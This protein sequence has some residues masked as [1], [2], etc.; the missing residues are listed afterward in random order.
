MVL[1]EFDTHSFLIVLH[2]S[3]TKKTMY[4]PAIISVSAPPLQ[5]HSLLPSGLTMKLQRRKPDLSLPLCSGNSCSQPHAVICENT[6]IIIRRFIDHHFSQMVLSWK[7][8]LFL[9]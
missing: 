3:A 2:L 8:L 9:E 1:T 4:Q 5:F 7:F 6:V